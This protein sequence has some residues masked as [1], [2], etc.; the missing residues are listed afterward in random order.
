MFAA[1]FAQY[2]DPMVNVHVIDPDDDE[3]GDDDDEDEDED[4]E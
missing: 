3:P 4:E 2:D 1:L